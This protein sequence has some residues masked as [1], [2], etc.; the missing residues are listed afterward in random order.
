MGTVAAAGV[1]ASSGRLQTSG[2]QLSALERSSQPPASPGSVADPRL[3]PSF[4]VNSPAPS[5]VLLVRVRF[6]LSPGGRE[7]TEA[8][9]GGGPASVPMRSEAVGSLQV[10]RLLAKPRD[11]AGKE[12]LQVQ[13]PR[14]GQRSGAFPGGH[15]KRGLRKACVTTACSGPG[16][17]TTETLSGAEVAARRSQTRGSS[18]L[19]RMKTPSK[20]TGEPQGPRLRSQ[21]VLKPPRPAP[22]FTPCVEGA[23]GLPWPRTAR[24]SLVHPTADVRC[25]RVRRAGVTL[26]PWEPRASSG[27]PHLS[28]GESPR[29]GRQHGPE[30][31]APRRHW[32]AS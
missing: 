12:Q 16:Q 3:S 23:W 25:S 14:E 13:S 31:K 21:I 32:A 27:S 4:H 29:A 20:A 9:A 5:P 30:G 17:L 6:V 15:T 18:P 2:T 26:R 24:A 28:H 10:G 8:A 22:P 11:D 1:A 7:T 19:G